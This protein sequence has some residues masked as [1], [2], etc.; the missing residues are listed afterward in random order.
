MLR[1]AASG[2]MERQERSKQRH[3]PQETDRES[4]GC[5]SH[6]HG[7]FQTMQSNDA[8]INGEQPPTGVGTST[9]VRD[10]P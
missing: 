5:A 3:C 4:P 10:E 7:R 8:E 2:E 6:I 9:D 1:A